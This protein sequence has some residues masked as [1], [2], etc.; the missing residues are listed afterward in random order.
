MLLGTVFTL[1]VNPSKN[2]LGYLERDRLNSVPPIQQANLLCKCLFRTLQ[3]I[4]GR[5]DTQQNS[6]QHNDTQHNDT[7]HNDTQHND[8]QHN[9]I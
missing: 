7:Q 4:K 5:L 1:G 8:T 2:L 9:D 6:I 3:C